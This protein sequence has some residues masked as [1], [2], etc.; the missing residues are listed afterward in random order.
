FYARMLGGDTFGAATL[1]ARKA[2]YDEARKAGQNDATWG[3]YQCYGDPDYRLRAPSNLRGSGDGESGFVAVS[4]AIDA[5]HRVYDDVNIGLERDLEA[6][7]ARL[8]A[9]EKAAQPW[10]GSAELRVALAEAWGEL[11]D[12]GKAVDHYSE[13]VKGADTSFK[14][15]AIEQLANLSLR[16]AVLKFR[17][18]PP[19]KR[20]L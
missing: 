13:A 2:T 5:A 10:I 4:E 12:L 20:D 15:K 14:A 16:D 18:L 3:A 9:I 11:G 6:L 7:R 8:Q 19:E 17:A 1:A